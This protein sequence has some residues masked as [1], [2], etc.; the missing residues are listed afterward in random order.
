MTTI[1]VTPELQLTIPKEAL[2]EMH[3]KSGQKFSV[4]ASK[5]IMH[6]VPMETL[7]SLEGF[8]KGMDTSDIRDEEDRF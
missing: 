6:I 4:I 8:L 7:E 1:T 5:G 2:E 3:I